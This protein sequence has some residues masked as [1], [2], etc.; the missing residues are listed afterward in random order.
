MATLC[1]INC[2]FCA[3]LVT[4]NMPSIIQRVIK[5]PAVFLTITA[6]VFGFMCVDMFHTTSTT[7]EG[8][9]MT[10]EVSIKSEQTCC[11]GT[12]SQ[13]IQSWT[14]TFLTTS[15]DL[16][17]NL[18]LLA[19]GLLIVLFFGRSRFSFDSTNQMLLSSRLYLRQ[20]PNLIIFNPL[21]LAFARGIL[22]P[23]LY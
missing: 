12:M 17:N 14:N 18:A 5:F 22:H 13:H 19:L 9:V 3:K 4:I 2:I 21:R 20:R 1:F 23:K 16:R 7:M 8:M 15:Q 10:P 11:G 6:L